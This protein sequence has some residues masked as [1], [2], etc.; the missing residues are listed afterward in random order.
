MRS[1]PPLVPCGTNPER[2][3]P[4]STEGF[5]RLGDTRL[6]P[7]H[8]E[9]HKL[10]LCHKSKSPM[11]D[12]FDGEAGSPRPAWATLKMVED[13]MCE[14]LLTPWGM[15]TTIFTFFRGGVKGRQR[16]R[17]GTPGSGLMSEQGWLLPR[18][19]RLAK[20]CSSV[21]PCPWRHETY[22]SPPPTA[23]AAHHEPQVP[24]LHRH[25][26]VSERETE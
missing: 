22:D 6:P 12:G 25:H 2:V 24:L 16:G 8:N 7:S 19:V 17:S 3:A 15:S 21:H 9:F 10:R 13:I 11:Q 26:I 14:I 23:T 18:V 5:C 4:E 1:P 20:S